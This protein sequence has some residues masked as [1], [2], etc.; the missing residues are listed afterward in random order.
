MLKKKFLQKLFLLKIFFLKFFVLI[1]GY[2]PQWCPKS[3]TRLPKATPCQKATKPVLKAK[4]R[5][6]CALKM[7][8]VITK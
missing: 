3:D 2:R 6:T 7:A 4:F 1:G 8:K 5:R